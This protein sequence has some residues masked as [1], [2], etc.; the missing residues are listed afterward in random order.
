MNRED[1]QKFIEEKYGVLPEY[2]WASSPSFAVFRHDNNKKW[3]AVVMNITKDKLGLDST[4]KID[5]VNLKCDP[6]MNVTTE[7]GVFP[8]YHMSKTHWI[9]V[10]L[11]GS[12]DEDKI[13]WL[14]DLSFDLTFK[15]SC[16]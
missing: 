12:V 11:D 14:L 15:R 4:E 2:P 16:K 10:C 8:A 7:T 6:I 9:S 1:F 13:K 5:V 3:F